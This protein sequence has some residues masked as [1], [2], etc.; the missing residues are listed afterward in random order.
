[1][2]ANADHTLRPLVLMLWRCARWM[3]AMAGSVCVLMVIYHFA[4]S[5]RPPW[6]RVLPGAVLATLSWFLSTMLY[7]WYVTRFADYSIVYGP[8]GAGVATMVWL[9]IVSL[10]MLLGAEF[11]A[12][13]HPLLEVSRQEQD[14]EDTEDAARPAYASHIV[15]SV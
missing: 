11:N 9:Y 14:D 7:G 10:A 12:Q 4:V 13:V 2:V 1:M 3:I 15:R 6:L 8:L 5:L